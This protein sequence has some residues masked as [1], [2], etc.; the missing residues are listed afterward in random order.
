MTIELNFDGGYLRC[1]GESSELKTFSIKFFL[2]LLFFAL[3][4]FHSK[5]IDWNFFRG[6]FFGDQLC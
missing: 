1:G 6:C 4:N 2:F 5:E 3:E